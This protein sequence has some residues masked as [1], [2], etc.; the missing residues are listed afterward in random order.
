MTAKYDNDFAA[1]A[2]EQAALLRQRDRGI[3]QLDWDNLAEEIEGMSRSDRREIVSRLEGLCQHLLKLAYQPRLDSPT[4]WLG[5]ISRQRRGIARVLKESPSLRSYAAAQL[6][7]AYH[8]GRDEAEKETGLLNLPETCP[9]TI[10]QVLDF[11]FL[12]PSPTR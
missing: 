9:W 11:E 10:E 8:G 2:D 12:P 6:Q 3:N 7:D 4:S 5:S 1:W